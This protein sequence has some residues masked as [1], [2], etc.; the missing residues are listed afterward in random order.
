MVKTLK[1]R[2]YVVGGTDGTHVMLYPLVSLVDADF[3]PDATLKPKYEFVFDGT[4][5]LNE[6]ELPADAKRLLIHTD[7]QYFRGEFVARTHL[8]QGHHL[9]AALLRSGAARVACSTGLLIHYGSSLESFEF[10][11]GEIGVFS[12][13]GS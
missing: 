3:R 1:V 11:F 4:T 8:G 9:R 13:E 7:A 12:V 10:G 6:F 2:S 5:L